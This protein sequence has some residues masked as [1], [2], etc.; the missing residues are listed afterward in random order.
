MIPSNK[1]FKILLTFLLLPLLLLTLS[2]KKKRQVESDALVFDSISTDQFI[3]LRAEVDSPA[4]HVSLLYAYPAGDQPMTEIFNSLFFGDSLKQMEPS[5]AMEAFLEILKNDY[6]A[7]NAMAN[8]EAFPASLLDY[9]YYQRNDIAYADS[10]L[11]AMQLTRNSYEGGVHPENQILYYNI[12]RKN[13]EILHETHLF[14]EP[15][16]EELSKIILTKL[17]QMFDKTNPQELDAEGF[18]NAEE[19]QPNDNFLV[20]N[21]GLKYCFNEYQI[22]AYAKGPIYVELSFE[23]LLPVLNPDSPIKHLLP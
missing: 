20:T 5:K 16:V 18:F 8:I 2:C 14:K 15:Y 12:C 10:I 4:L 9:E 7:D 13:G 22:A 17:M 23:E 19:I 1:S 6:R 3:P 21:T 11:L